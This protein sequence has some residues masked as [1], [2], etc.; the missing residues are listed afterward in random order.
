MTNK[1]PVSGGLL[2]SEEQKG[3]CIDLEDEKTYPQSRG[4]SVH[5][6]NVDYLCKAQ[7][8]HV[9]DRVGERLGTDLIKIMIERLDEICMHVNS[10]EEELDGETKMITYFDV[11]KDEWDGLENYLNKKWDAL[12]AELQEEIK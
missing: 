8:Q 6:A 2:L 1:Q 12:R 10:D 5:L 11:Y 9:L 7:A 4:G 3:D